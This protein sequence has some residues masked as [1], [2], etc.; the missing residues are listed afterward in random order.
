MDI[1]G[2]IGPSLPG[3]KTAG[4]VTAILKTSVDV[5]LLDYISQLLQN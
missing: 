2:A 1:S 4:L 3:T 5:N